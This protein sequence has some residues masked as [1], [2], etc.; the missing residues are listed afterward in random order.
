[1]RGGGTEHGTTVLAGRVV[2]A[3]EGRLQV[4]LG[5]VLPELGD[6]RVRVDD[7]VLELPPD[8]LYLP[9]VDVLDG[10]APAVDLDGAARGARDVDGPQR[11]KELL[12]VLDLAV[13][14]LDRLHDPVRVRVGLFRE[15]RRNLPRLLLEGGRELPICGGGVGVAVLHERR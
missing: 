10:V 4:L 6:V 2:T 8:L 5:V 7:R 13:D 15:V 1:M 3:V 11:P 9:D 14:G 12:A